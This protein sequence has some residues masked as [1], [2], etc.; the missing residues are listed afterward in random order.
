MNSLTRCPTYKELEQ[1]FNEQFT[2]LASEVIPFV[3][4]RADECNDREIL[5]TNGIC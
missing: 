5:L 4:C 3:G 1:A 2:E